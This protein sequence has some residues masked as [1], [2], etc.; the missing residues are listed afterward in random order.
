VNIV[1]KNITIWW[2]KIERK[3]VDGQLL[4]VYTSD[5][6]SGKGILVP[7][8]LLWGTAENRRGIRREGG[9]G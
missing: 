2:G 1:A 7:E 4:F 9:E 6:G 3:S 5:S 8:Y